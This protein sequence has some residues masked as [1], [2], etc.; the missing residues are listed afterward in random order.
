M[1]VPW[2]EDNEMKKIRDCILS[3]GPSCCDK[4]PVCDSEY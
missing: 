1:P 2:V 3:R 4:L